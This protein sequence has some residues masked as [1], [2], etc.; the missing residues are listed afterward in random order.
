[1]PTSDGK[2]CDVTEGFETQKP[3]SHGSSGGPSP[4]FPGIRSFILAP[5]SLN[6][7]SVA[8]KSRW[9]IHEQKSGSPDSSDEASWVT[10]EH[11]AKGPTA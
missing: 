5:R 2:A 9:A 3:G 8:A 1:M 4:N 10:A 11:V 6:D 7:A